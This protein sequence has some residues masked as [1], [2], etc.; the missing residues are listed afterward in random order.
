MR[1]NFYSVL[2]SIWSCPTY[3]GFTL[4]YLVKG[5]HSHTTWVANIANEW[6]PVQEQNLPYLHNESNKNQ[7]SLMSNSWKLSILCADINCLA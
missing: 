6:L 7:N 4:V 5:H 1:E 3:G 2:S